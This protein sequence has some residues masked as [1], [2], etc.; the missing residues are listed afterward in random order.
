MNPSEL[1][2]TA[3]TTWSGFVY[4][5]KVAIYHVLSLLTDLE[6]HGD[7]L[8]QLDSLDDF[9]ILS[10]V[11]EIVSLHQVKAKKTQNFSGYEEAITKL[12]DNANAHNC[13]N[14]QFHIAREII[15]KSVEDIETEYSPVKIYKYDTNGWCSVN[16]ID[17]KIE[18]ELK[19]LFSAWFVGDESKQSQE[20]LKKARGYL[21]QIVLIKVLAIHKIIHDSMLPERDAAYTQIIEFSKFV[22]V[23]KRDLN[24]EELGVDYYYYLLLEYLYRYY[25]EF[26]IENDELSDDDLVILSEC[27][28][29]VGGLSKSDMTQ[30]I[31]NIMPHRGFEFSTL[32]QFKDSTFD[33]DGVKDAFLTILGKLKKPEFNLANYFYWISDDITYSPTT[34]DKGVSQAGKVCNRIIVNAMDSDLSIM[35]EGSSL[36]TTDIDVD[37]L[38]EAAPDLIRREYSD[39]N[40][41]ENILMW[42]KVSLVSLA[43]AKD[44]IND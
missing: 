20:Y 3:I 19:V 9:A 35:F 7:F 4:Q 27:M 8:L 28:K 22:E 2:H 18:G 15:D 16:D 33:E 31:R 34:I 25:Q 30:F 32:E 5:G 11:D 38:T 21:D 17:S 1:P 39:G 36:I 40:S 43:N 6:S 10:D 26:C 14:A 44:I 41:C 13:E 37:S 29:E 42:K 12:R 24:Q 23:L